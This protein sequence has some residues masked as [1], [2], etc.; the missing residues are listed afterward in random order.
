MKISH[1]N[2]NTAI[3]SELG[4]RIKKNRLDMQMSQ[5]EFAHRAGI[6]TR[7]LSVAENGGDIRLESLIRIM[8]ILGTIE[9]F[10]LLLPELTINPEDYRTL[11]ME[12]QRVSRKTNRE[13]KSGKWKW[14]MGT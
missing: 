8:R 5:Q 12:R 7:T 14:G 6:S 10:N 4:N 1:D 13:Q 2:S 9:N 3:M 11:G